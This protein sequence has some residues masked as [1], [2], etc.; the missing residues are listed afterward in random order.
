MMTAESLDVWRPL[1]ELATLLQVSERTIRRRATAGQIDVCTIAGKRYGRPLVVKAA[2][3]DDADGAAGN[4]GTGEDART[5]PDDRDRRHPETE[6]D[7][8]GRALV[9]LM[10]AHDRVQA[11]EGERADLVRQLLDSER[12]ATERAAELA[13][14]RTLAEVATRDAERERAE[15]EQAAAELAE[16]RRRAAAEHERSRRLAE[17]ATLPWHRWRARR[18]ILDACKVGVG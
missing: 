11:L 2:A 4:N 13:E 14:L 12:Q 15:R 17:A 7:G 3:D 10:A 16:A 8:N 5:D 6:A 9:L 18:R 1:S